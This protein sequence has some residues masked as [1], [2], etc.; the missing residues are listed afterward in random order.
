MLPIGSGSAPAVF[1]GR[2]EVI[3]A[4]AEAG[5]LGRGGASLPVARKWSTVA[6]VR[7][8]ERS[9]SGTAQRVSRLARRIGS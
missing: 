2:G 9:C 1:S 3:R 6:D 5:L 7:T 8:V 4:I